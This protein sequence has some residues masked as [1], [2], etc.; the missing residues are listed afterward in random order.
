MIAY[1]YIFLSRLAFLLLFGK[2]EKKSRYIVSYLFKQLIFML[3]SIIICMEQLVKSQAGTSQWE[4][5]LVQSGLPKSHLFFAH[6]VTEDEVF[7]RL[8][9]NCC[10]NLSLSSVELSAL[11]GEAWMKYA[12][13][14][15]FAFFSIKDSAKAFILDM[16]RTHTKVTDKLENAAPPKFTYH[17]IDNNTLL[18]DYSS[19]RDLSHI[20]IGL[21]KAVGNHFG[22]NI[23]V[24]ETKKNQVRILFHGKK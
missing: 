16:D 11:F 4:T 13:E 8:F 7:E 3:G 24:T 15:Y 5:I 19:K 22:E 14:K 1:R 17:E 6:R 20:W 9:E 23:E 21:L 18:M 10:K 2:F 12:K